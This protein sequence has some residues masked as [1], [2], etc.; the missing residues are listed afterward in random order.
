MG[1]RVS[2]RLMAVVGVGA[3]VGVATPFAVSAAAP[4]KKAS[5]AQIRE[6]FVEWNA[7]LA[8]GD[9]GKVA[10]RYAADAVLVP[11]VS[12]EVRAD[13]ARIVDYFDHFLENDPTAVITESHV[14]V[15]DAD[16]AVDTGTYRFTLG[17]DRTVD[18]R[19]TF[20]YEQRDG[21]WLIVNHHSS[22]MPE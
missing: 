20:V 16:T 18:A 21:A 22:A 14:S 12:N 6:L 7:S 4:G 2:K 5:E 9:S 11:T 8:T 13:R 15:L 1:V 19:Y 17:G 3:V 10:D